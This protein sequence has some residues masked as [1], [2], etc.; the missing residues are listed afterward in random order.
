LAG[1]FQFLSDIKDALTD[2]AV[3]VPAYELAPENIYPTQLRQCIDALRYLLD[4]EG[5]APSDITIGG[6]SAG[7]NLT[8]GV[9]SHI[10]HPHPDIPPLTIPSKLHAAML[11]S[12]WCSF[13]VHTP[14]YTT[15]AEKDMFD[16]RTLT[17]W[18]TAFLGSTSP[19]AG[20][21]YNEPVLAPASWWEPVADVVSEALIWGGGNEILLDGIEEL[22]RRFQ[23]GY[24]GQGGVVD[25]VIT[26]NAAHIEMVLERVLGYKGE[27]MGGTGTEEAIKGWVK[28]RL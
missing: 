27:K 1:H 6:D 7:G 9:L 3:L 11:L 23:K 21:F 13:N 15:N 22:A 20:D 19:F 24:G 4:A 8:L 26:P 16:A 14:S 28:A 17:R 25:T 10:A 5:R 12:P 18:S 2:T